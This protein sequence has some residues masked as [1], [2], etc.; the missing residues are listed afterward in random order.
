MLLPSFLFVASA[1]STLVSA[2]VDRLS[3]AHRQ[4]ARSANAEPEPY[5]LFGAKDASSP[6]VKRDDGPTFARIGDAVNEVATA[7]KLEMPPVV[8]LST[9][10]GSSSAKQ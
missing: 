1:A 9:L 8:Q 2:R 10:N 7:L 3:S 6:F 4:F 5:R